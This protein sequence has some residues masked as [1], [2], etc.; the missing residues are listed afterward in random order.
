MRARH[1]PAITHKTSASC[2]MPEAVGVFSS[3][4]FLLRSCLVGLDL[5]TVR[6]A[7]I[8]KSACSDRQEFP[9]ITGWFQGKLQYTVRGVV[10][11]FAVG[12][13]PAQRRQLCTVCADFELTHAARI[14][15]PALAVLRRKT[16]VVLVMR[17]QH[18]V[19]AC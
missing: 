16:L 12:L 13:A 11:H 1:R 3:V 8:G 7:T 6:D 5:M 14:V 18:Q 19:R 9:F 2:R 15:A 10:F 17:H 4:S